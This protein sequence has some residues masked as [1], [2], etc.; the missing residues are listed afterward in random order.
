[1]RGITACVRTATTQTTDSI[2]NREL[3]ECGDG[4]DGNLA[5]ALVPHPGYLVQPRCQPG[6][7]QLPSDV[8][9]TTDIEATVDQRGGD[10]RDLGNVIEQFDPYLAVAP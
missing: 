1:M 8:R 3:V 7:V 2:E 5:A 9:G 10:V 4:T 6:L